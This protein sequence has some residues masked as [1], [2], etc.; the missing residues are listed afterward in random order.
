MRHPIR[1]LIQD[2]EPF[3][4]Q[5]RRCEASSAFADLV[6]EAERLGDGQEREDRVEGGAFLEGF[7]QDASAAA[8]ENVVDAAED[9]G[10]WAGV[11]ERNPEGKVEVWDRSRDL[12][13]AWIS[14]EYMASIKRGLQSLKP[15]WI[16]L[17][18]VLITSPVSRPSLSRAEISSSMDVWTTTSSRKTA[19]P[20]TGSLQR[21]PCAV[22]SWNA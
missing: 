6:R 7:G 17:C 19:I 2:L 10:C 16:L 4:L 5:L 8:V 13:L 20:W 1:I 11:S 9:F 12:L 18:T 3:E 22:A 14:H 15:W 21:G